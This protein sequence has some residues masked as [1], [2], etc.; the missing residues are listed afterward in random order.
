MSGTM[1]RS[2]LDDLAGTLM[3]ISALFPKGKSMTHHAQSAPDIAFLR[4]IGIAL[5][6]LTVAVGAISVVG[7]LKAGEPW[8]VAQ[9]LDGN[10]TASDVGILSVDHLWL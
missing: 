1:M 7:C 3:L 10:I 9:S 4:N 5:L 6:G 2:N 8:M